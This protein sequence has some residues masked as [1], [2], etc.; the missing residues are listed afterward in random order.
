[1][2]QFFIQT[3]QGDF[4]F[5]FYNKSTL[6]ISEADFS[7]QQTTSA[8]LFCGLASVDVS[9]MLYLDGLFIDGEE[10]QQYRNEIGQKFI[11]E[12]FSDNLN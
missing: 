7:S 2:Q 8:P 3:S 5:N 4:V 1:M 6:I 10:A 9:N 11:N 12:L